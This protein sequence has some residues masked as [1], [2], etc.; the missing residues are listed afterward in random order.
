MRNR[1]Q[2]LDERQPVREPLRVG[3]LQRGRVV[4]RGIQREG[5][6]AVGAERPVGVEADPPGPA[7]YADVEV[8]DPP[9][10]AAR[11]EDGE[12][13]DDGEDPERDPQEEEDDVVRDRQQPLDEPE[14]AAELGVQVSPQRNWV[15]GRPGRG[16]R[17]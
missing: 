11:E 13:S 12:E 4:G 3:D 1:E 2:P 16:S 7:Q 8:E 9:W 17:P 6:V 14:P 5:R 10:V 15:D